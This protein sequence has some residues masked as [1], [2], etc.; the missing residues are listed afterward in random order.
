MS[1]KGNIF[2]FKGVTDVTDCITA[3]EVMHKAG[4]DWNVAKGEIYTKMPGETD[5]NLNID[6]PN[7]FFH[8]SNSFKPIENI[9][10]TYRCDK[11]IPLGIVKGRYTPVQNKDAFKFF[12]DVIGKNEVSWFTAGC[13]GNGEKVFVSAKLSDSILVNGKDPIDTYLVFSTSHNGDTGI[14]IML[15]PIRLVCFNAMNAAI[16][17]ANNY[18]NIRHTNSVHSKISD[19]NQILKISKKNIKSFGDAMEQ[20][21]KIKMSDKNAFEIFGE[22]LL[23]SEELHNLAHWG[24]TLDQL[25]KRNW[26]AIEASNISSK[27]L[28]SFCEMVE[29]YHLGAGQREYVGTGYGVYNAVN[30]YYSNV[31]NQDGLKRMDN[32]I[33]GTHANKIKLASDLILN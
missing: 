14:K 3:E 31:Y 29:Y 15:T 13:Y 2:T 26:E 8:G 24:F 27:K 6:N 19:A 12:N 25:A 30:G 5:F 7:Q 17:N 9:F 28:N 1:V 22:I 11:N 33:Y 32:L 23:S 4:L 16:R 20:M 10:A 21:V 18:I